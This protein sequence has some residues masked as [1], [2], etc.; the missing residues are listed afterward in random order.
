MAEAQLQFSDAAGCRTWLSRLP[1]ANPAQCHAALLAQARLLPAST[2]AGTARLEILEL[3]RE[4]VGRTQAEMI[5]GCRGKPVPLK[6]QHQEAWNNVV[7]LWQA[8]AASYDCLIDAM[9]STA[10]DLATSAHLICQ[11]A[12]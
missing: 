1:L 5:K 7:G 3:R 6:A 9:A 11:R 10:P 2:I 8:M 4:P 12:L